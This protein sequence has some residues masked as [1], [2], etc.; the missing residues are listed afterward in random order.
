MSPPKV[1]TIADIRAAGCAKLEPKW[2]QYINE[3]SMDL[4]TVK[5][6][7]AA[8]D[9]YR[10][11]PRILR[12]VEQIDTSTTLFGGKVT[13]PFAFS[14]AAMHCLAHPDGEIGTSRAAAKAGIAMG[15]SHW[16]TKSLEDVIQAG[17]E[18]GTGIPYGLQTS[19]ANQRKY[20]LGL[21]KRAE[22]AGYKAL[23][24][25]VDAPTLG[26]RLNEYRNGID[27]PPGFKFPN[28]E[29][30][31]KSFRDT[32]R[33]ADNTFA[34]LLPWLSEVTPPDMEIWLKGI[35]TPED[36]LSASSYPRIKGVIVSNHG[37]R[38]LDGAPAT[39]EA[40]PACAAAVRSVNAARAPENK[41][42][43][44]ID[45]GIRRGSDIFKALA[46]GA[47][48]CFAGRIPIWSL[49]YNGPEGV[50]HAIQILKE[51]FEMCMRLSGCKTLADIGPESLAIVEGGVPGLITRLSKL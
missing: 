4:I 24:L 11:M 23:L 48:I 35:Y 42:M 16:A 41:L 5:A 34:N 19:S 20:T 26:R 36:V 40:L 7:E 1:F 47:D 46:L 25:T 38:Q 39:L 43:L 29:Y 21:L 13:F 18:I 12:D 51:E 17:K 14:P 15:L 9:R 44:G 50:E 3:G 6:N 8:Y 37:G 28:I 31:P 45:G 2:A 30:D 22:K 49:A 10:I 32:K 27:L 33:D